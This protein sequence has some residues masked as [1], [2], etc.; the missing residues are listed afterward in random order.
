MRCVQLRPAYLHERLTF[1]YR[2]KETG[3]RHQNTNCLA[4]TCQEQLDTVVFTIDVRNFASSTL[5][6]RGRQS[7]KRFLSVTALTCL[8]AVSSLAGDLHTGGSPDRKSTRLN[9]SHT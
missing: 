5:N 8:L 2:C 1:L 4:E 9:S 6:F 3:K 7:M